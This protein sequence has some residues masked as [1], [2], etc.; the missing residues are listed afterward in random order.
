[1][2]NVTVK[3]RDQT[4]HV[5]ILQIG[6][7]RPMADIRPAPHQ[8][9]A[10]EVPETIGSLHARRQV[11][12]KHEAALPDLVCALGKLTMK[13]LNN[14]SRLKRELHVRFCERLVVRFIKTVT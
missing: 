10:C 3:G 14:K 1:M 4:R 13:G 5:W 2:V 9:G 12:E 11:V 7:L 6:A 8:L